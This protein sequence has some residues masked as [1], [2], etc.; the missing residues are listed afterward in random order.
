MFGNVVFAGYP[1]PEVAR[2]FIIAIAAETRPVY[3]SVFL[4]Y[5]EDLLYNKQIL[6]KIE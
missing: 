3:L 2:V 6:L 4:N 5:P 1:E